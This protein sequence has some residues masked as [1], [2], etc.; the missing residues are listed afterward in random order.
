[1]AGLTREVGEHAK[2]TLRDGSSLLTPISNQ[3][4]LSVMSSPSFLS[5]LEEGFVLLLCLDEGIFEE[6]GI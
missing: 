4:Y 3:F 5:L 6:I 2:E 1:M